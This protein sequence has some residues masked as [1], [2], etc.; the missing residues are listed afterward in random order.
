MNKAVEMVSDTRSCKYDY[1]DAFKKYKPQ[2]V[3]DAK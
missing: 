2:K 1:T 3:K